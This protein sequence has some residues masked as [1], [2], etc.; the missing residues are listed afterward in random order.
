MA[1]MLQLIL[2][3]LTINTNVYSTSHIYSNTYILCI[4]SKSCTINCINKAHC[5]NKT[6]ICPSDQNCNINCQTPYSCQ[7][8]TIIGTNSSHLTLHALSHHSTSHS[9]IHCPLSK[10]ST[11]HIYG[12]SHSTNQWNN[13]NI[14]TYTYTNHKLICES[15][16]PCANDKS[17]SLI[18]HNPNNSTSTCQLS[19]LDYK[20]IHTRNLLSTP[21]TTVVN[22]TKSSSK[23]NNSPFS[24]H[25]TA[26]QISWILFGAVLLVLLLICTLICLTYFMCKQNKQ[27]HNSKQNIRVNTTTS[28]DMQLRYLVLAYQDGKKIKIPFDISTLDRLNGEND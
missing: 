1:F 23:S 17:I 4:S 11:C 28:S 9:N 15:I 20:C 22:S 6:I 26:T 27:K 2:F 21:S 7:N 12:N 18:Q 19:H 10:S 25:M 16:Y 3:I 5:T 14:H 13:M 8:T 24:I